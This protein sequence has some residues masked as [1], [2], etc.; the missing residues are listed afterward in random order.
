M[1]ESGGGAIVNVGSMWAIDAIAR[2]HQ[3]LLGSPG[4][5]PRLDE[6]PGDRARRREH[7]RQHRRARVRRDP[8][9]RAV[10]DRRPGPRRTR[11]GEPVPSPRT[12]WLSRST[13]SRRSSFSPVP[14]PAGSRER[15]S[16]STAASSPAEMRPQ[17]PFGTNPASD[18][19][20][21]PGR[22]SRMR[23]RGP[24]TT[25]HHLLATH[26]SDS[27]TRPTRGSRLTSSYGSRPPA[28]KCST[29]DV[30]RTSH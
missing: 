3:R 15:R 27:G 29:A 13:S 24:P 19:R 23:L 9:L 18:L 14:A 1:V 26:Q 4:R 10:H 17:C 8:G 16:R 7:P 28:S 2:L 20:R 30:R 11:V 5:P 25:E 22:G 6:E 21:D 12:P